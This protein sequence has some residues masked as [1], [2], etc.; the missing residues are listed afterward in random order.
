M[1]PLKLPYDFG[2]L[3]P[4]SHNVNEPLDMHIEALAEPG[5]TTQALDMLTH[6]M[7]EPGRS[8]TWQS[9]LTLSAATDASLTM[10]LASLS[11]AHT[12][13]MKALT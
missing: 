9:S 10:T 13:S 5:K 4:S 3:R 7:A 1:L 2:S 11:P 8:E 12:M 6:A